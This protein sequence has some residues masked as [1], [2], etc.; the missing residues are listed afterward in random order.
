MRR[1]CSRPVRVSRS[2]SARASS[3]VAGSRSTPS[4]VLDDHLG[5]RQPL[6][7]HVVD[8]ELEVLGV[9]AQ[10]EGQAGLRVEV[11]EQHPV[12]ELGQRGPD[13]GDGRRLGDATLLV[14][15]REDVSSLVIGAHHAGRPV[16]WRSTHLP[17]FDPCPR[18]H[19]SPAPRPASATPSPTSSRPAATTWSWSPATRN[20]WR[21]W[22]PSCA[23]PYGVEVE[24]L[25][26]DLTDRAD[27][28]RVE[29]RLA[30]A[31]PPGRPAGQQRR[32][33]AQGAVPR[34]LRRRRAGDAR[35]PGHRGAAALATPRS[36][37]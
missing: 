26:A 10:R 31:D 6:G 22:P 8:R 13:R 32:L 7:Q 30:D 5:R 21:R 28:A 14:G 16:P 17:D 1:T 18:P 20:G 2:A 27:L 23:P 34:Q 25:P 33:R 4:S 3:M 11:D 24:V 19:S 29:A 37:R 9:D 12:A 15:D 35:R 36:G